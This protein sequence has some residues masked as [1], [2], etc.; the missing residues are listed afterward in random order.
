MSHSYS[1]NLVHCVFSTKTRAD[2]IPKDIQERLYAYV[3]GTARK[4][5]IQ[6]LALGRTANHVHVLMVLPA[7]KTLSDA[8][9]D[10]KANSSRWMRE[11]CSEFSWQEGFGAFS[12][13]P[14]SAEI[15]KQY[16]RNQALHHQK[17]NF[18]EEFVTLLRK[19]RVSYDPKYVFD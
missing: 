17:R 15:V 2:S 19:C 9:R 13:S 12:V 5:G 10:L 6:I 1:C 4:L 3:Q 16:I 18:E 7:T 11:K 14:S 8:V